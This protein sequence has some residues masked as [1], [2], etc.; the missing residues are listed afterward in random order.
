MDNAENAPRNATSRMP[1]VACAMAMVRE[2]QDVCLVA[3]S[4]TGV[5][6]MFDRV[7]AYHIACLVSDL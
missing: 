2:G 6:P 5:F 4:Q 7:Q 1:L 3:H